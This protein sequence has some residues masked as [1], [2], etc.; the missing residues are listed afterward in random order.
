MKKLLIVL[1]LML[2]CS[3]LFAKQ[4]YELT[5]IY[6]SAKEWGAAVTVAKIKG[7]EVPFITDKVNEYVNN[8]IEKGYRIIS[9]QVVEDKDPLINVNHTGDVVVRLSILY[10]DIDK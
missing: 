2:M 9:I 6:I 8:L 5:D 7:T 3:G 10:E 4:H 1:A